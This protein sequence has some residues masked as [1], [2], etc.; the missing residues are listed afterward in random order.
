MGDCRPLAL[1]M[2]WPMEGQLLLGRQPWQVPHTF[3]SFGGAG[4]TSGSACLARAM[5]G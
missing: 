2:H 5:W 4:S 3:F 1:G